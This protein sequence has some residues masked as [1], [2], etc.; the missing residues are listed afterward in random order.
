M[1]AAALVPAC[2]AAV[3]LAG[4]TAVAAV[5][6]D[7]ETGEGFAGRKDVRSAFGWSTA[8]FRDRAGELSF[9]YVDAK[10]YRVT[11][12][13]GGRTETV[14]PHT[15]NERHVTDKPRRDG[16]TLVGFDLVGYAGGTSSTNLFQEEG[17][18]CGGTDAKGDFNGVWGPVEQTSEILGLVVRYRGQQRLLT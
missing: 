6:F 4:G 15:A 11:C 14:R 12:S 18:R 9:A 16:G 10:R 5:S 8:E 3:L 1:L 2:A 13:S 17:E 7:V